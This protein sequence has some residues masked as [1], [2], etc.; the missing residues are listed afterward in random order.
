LKAYFPKRRIRNCPIKIFWCG[1]LSK[2]RGEKWSFP[3]QVERYLRELCAGKSTL[4]LFGGKAKFGIRLDTDC[5]TEPDVIGD[6]F[7]PPFARASFDTVIVDPPY[8]PYLALGPSTVRPLLMNAAY[9]AKKRVIW[10]APLWVSGYTWLRLERSYVVRVGDYCELR[11][12]QFLRPTL[13]ADFR[14]VSHF[15]HGP[16]VK[17]NKWLRQPQMLPFGSPEEAA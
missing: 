11:S 15:T 7:L 16:A 5:F 14:P 4:H 2:K 9:I 6:A 3:P 10:F 13:P 12:L 8:P 17:Y 1:N